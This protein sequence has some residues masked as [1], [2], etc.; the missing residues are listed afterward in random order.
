MKK[1][2]LFQ[3]KKFIFHVINKNSENFSVFVNSRYSWRLDE[4]F[5]SNIWKKLNVSEIIFFCMLK[6]NTHTKLVKLSFKEHNVT[7]CNRKMT[8]FKITLTFGKLYMYGYKKNASIFSL[9]YVMFLLNFTII[10]KCFIV[11]HYFKFL[12]KSKVF[13][14]YYVLITLCI[15]LINIWICNCYLR[16]V[17]YGYLKIFIS[18]TF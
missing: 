6:Y 2:R 10:W 13:V 15:L 9:N 5:Y 17:F 3:L 14:Y 4:I 12:R 1:I 16:M 7:G 18:F 8:V 11:S